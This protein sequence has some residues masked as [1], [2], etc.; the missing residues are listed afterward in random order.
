MIVVIPQFIFY[1]TYLTEKTETENPIEIKLNYLEAQLRSDL[2]KEAHKY[3]YIHTE[4]YFLL[5]Y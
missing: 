4:I 2:I 5:F 1:I 3:D